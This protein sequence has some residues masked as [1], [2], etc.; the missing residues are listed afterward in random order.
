MQCTATLTTNGQLDPR[1]NGRS[2]L[3]LRARFVVPDCFGV[4]QNHCRCLFL[5]RKRAPCRIRRRGLWLFAGLIIPYDLRITQHSR[6]LLL[7]VTA[8]GSQH[9]S[10]NESQTRCKRASNQHMMPHTNPFNLPQ[11]AQIVLSVFMFVL[12]S[13]S[14]SNVQLI[15]KHKKSTLVIS[16][17]RSFV[18]ACTKGG[19]RK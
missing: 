11:Q 6:S 9:I 4:S 2:R 13:I 15:R 16:H 8:C 18:Q 7:V 3:Q 14:H 19:R 12:Q 5:L 10:T 17:R 1:L